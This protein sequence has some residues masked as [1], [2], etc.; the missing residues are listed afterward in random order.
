MDTFEQLAFMGPAGGIDR[1]NQ[2]LAEQI[3]ARG[4]AIGGR[5]AL[6]MR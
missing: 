4:S 1:C 5:P 2:H 3:S 6:A